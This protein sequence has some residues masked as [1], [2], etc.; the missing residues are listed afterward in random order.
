MFK[1]G[2]PEKVGCR[3][4]SDHK[5]VVTKFMPVT[6]SPM[7][8]GH[9]LGGEVDLLHF[10]IEEL[11]VL[12]QLSDRIDDVGHVEITRRDFM[13]HWREQRMVLAIDNR[14]TN[15]GI[16]GYGLFQ[17]QRGVK[18]AESRTKYQD[19]LSREF[20]FDVRSYSFFTHIGP[21]AR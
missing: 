4:Q 9:L 15:T 12:Q 1:S 5:V 6:L 2:Q 7:H 16:A 8:H 11:H 20:H 19:S 17:A 18:S 3:S 10:A 21:P 14:D 13:Q